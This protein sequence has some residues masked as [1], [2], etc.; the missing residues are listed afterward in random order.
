MEPMGTGGGRFLEHAGRLA[1][2]FLHADVGDKFGQA[3]GV[4]QQFRRLPV[5]AV[6]GQA[7]QFAVWECPAD[8]RRRSSGWGTARNGWPV[9]WRWLHRRAGRLR[10]NRT[11][12]PALAAS[13][14]RPGPTRARH[15]CLRRPKRALYPLS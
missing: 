14:V 11:N 8:R 1:H 15:I 10:R 9:R 7:E 13:E 2:P 4:E 3:L 12:G 6:G 5:L